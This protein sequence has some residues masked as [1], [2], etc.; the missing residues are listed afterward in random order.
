[1]EWSTVFSTKSSW[2]WGQL[3]NEVPKLLLWFSGYHWAGMLSFLFIRNFNFRRKSSKGRGH[4]GIHCQA[5]GNYTHFPKRVVSASD[6]RPSTKSIRWYRQQQAAKF[7]GSR[8]AS[9]RR[10]PDPSAQVTTT[11]LSFVWVHHPKETA[12]AIK[13]GAS[14]LGTTKQRNTA[15]NLHPFSIRNTKKPIEGSP[16]FL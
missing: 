3:W 5:E 12:L 15:L 10:R 9:C 13:N 14:D 2:L 1:M 8:K 4:T 7:L 6:S 16:L 11:S